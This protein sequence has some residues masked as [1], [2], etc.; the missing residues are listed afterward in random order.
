MRVFKFDARISADGI[1]QIPHTPSLL[2]QEVELIIVI[3][4]EIK[5]YMLN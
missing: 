1:I 2:E 3:Q 5:I 4:K